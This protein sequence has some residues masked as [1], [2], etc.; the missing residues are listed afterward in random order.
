MGRDHFMARLSALHFMSYVII[1]TGVPRHLL[2]VGVT[3]GPALYRV[4]CVCVCVCVCGGEGIGD[5]LW[6]AAQHILNIH[7][8]TI[9]IYMM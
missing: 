5:V 6:C 2:G 8:N 9:M 7:G 3:T 1:W 4:V